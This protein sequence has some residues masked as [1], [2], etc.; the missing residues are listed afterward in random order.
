MEEYNNKIL[1]IEKNIKEMNIAVNK[2]KTELDKFKLKVEKIF[3]Q[4]L[5]SLIEIYSV[6]NSIDIILNKSNLL[7][8]KKN[9]DITNDILS[10]FNKN[11]EKIDIK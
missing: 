5:N 3:S 2:N 9:L 6:D 11:F 1:I 10:L 8:A 4:K 7:I